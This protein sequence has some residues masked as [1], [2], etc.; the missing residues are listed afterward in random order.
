[1]LDTP[2]SAALADFFADSDIESLR[3]QG[4]ELHGI[5]ITGVYCLH[6]GRKVGSFED[7][8]IQFAIEEESAEDDE[9]LIDALMSRVVASMRP[10]PMLN[11]PDRVTLTNL[12]MKFPVDILSYLINRLHSNRYLATHRPDDVLDPYIARIK[13]HALWTELKLAG[14]D[15]SPWIHWLLEL[16]AKRN[17][18]DLSPPTQKDSTESLFYGITKENESQLLAQFELWTFAKLKEFDS[19]DREAKAQA[20]WMRGNTMSQSAYAHS[21]LENPQFASKKAADAHKQRIKPKKVLSE[22][23][24][25]LNA[26][27]S[28]FLHLLDDIIDSGTESPAVEKP[29][30]KILTGGMLF[31]KQGESVT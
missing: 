9:T 25:K 18:H 15:L 24:A 3:L 22:K 26:K 27:V 11:K 13:T 10:S 16:D 17:L 19:R 14:I 1:M 20:E 12:A 2:N 23:T 31:R 28:Q 6:T 29:K 30:A 5:D 8:V 4:L 21:W 7:F